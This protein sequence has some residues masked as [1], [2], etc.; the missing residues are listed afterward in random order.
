ME[1]KQPF[2]FIPCYTSLQVSYM[3]FDNVDKGVFLWCTVT[4][5]FKES[6]W[7]NILD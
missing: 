7:Y 4:S 3:G 1:Y 2:K 5:C 6:D